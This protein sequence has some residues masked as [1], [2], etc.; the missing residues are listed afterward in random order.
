MIEFRDDVRY[1]E[2]NE[3]AKFFD[4]VVRVGIDDYSQSSLGDVVHVEII[5]KG[6][7][8]TAG[9]PLGSIEATKSVSEINAPVSGVI[10][11]VNDE[12]VKNPAILNIDPF[13]EGWLAEISPDDPDEINSLMTQL[14]YKA[15]ISR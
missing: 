2:S 12:A 6:R 8:V 5:G 13:G 1:T 14:E 7:R 9:Q 3:W 4:G 10:T 15:F 11:L